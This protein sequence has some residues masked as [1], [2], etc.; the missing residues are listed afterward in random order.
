LIAPERPDSRH[1]RV[2]LMK[3]Q[4]AY[5]LTVSSACKVTTIPTLLPAETA[6]RCCTS[7]YT[8]DPEWDCVSVLSTPTV[9]PEI[10]YESI[11]VTVSPSPTMKVLGPGMHIRYQSSDFSLLGIEPEETGRAGALSGSNQDSSTSPSSGLSQVAKIA[12]GVTIPVVVLSALL[13]IIW[14]FW[15]R[16]KG[17]CVKASPLSGPSEPWAKPELET[18]EARVAPLIDRKS[19]VEPSTKTAGDNYQGGSSGQTFARDG[20]I[21]QYQAVPVGRMAADEAGH[22]AELGTGETS[23]AV[24]LDVG[25]Q[26]RELGAN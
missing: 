3:L 11:L 12:I 17:A 16:K 1:L 25:E 14:V 22:G 4:R 24:E 19:E 26:R 15:W 8:C 23:E 2:Y 5:Q 18:I 20:I 9:V 6:V 10:I 21:Y 13:C 7:H